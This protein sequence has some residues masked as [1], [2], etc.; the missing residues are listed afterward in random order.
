M[1]GPLA[2]YSQD[3]ASHTFTQTTHNAKYRSLTFVPVYD[4]YGFS[5]WIN[6]NS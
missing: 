5:T 2:S 1:K 3:R 6:S 4:S